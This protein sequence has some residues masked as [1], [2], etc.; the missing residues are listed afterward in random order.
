MKRMTQVVSIVALAM[1]L[2]AP[3]MAAEGAAGVHD[4][5]CT[6][7]CEM[8]V[9]N[10]RTEVDSLQQR[11]QRLQAAIKN[12]AESYSKEELNNMRNQLEETVKTLED[13]QQGGA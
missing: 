1:A 7:E 8:Q 6:K 4:A 12:H 2:S 10:C 3:A 5:N 9:R 13:L 11:I